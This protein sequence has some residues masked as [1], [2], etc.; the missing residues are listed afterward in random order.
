MPVRILPEF[1]P[2]AFGFAVQINRNTQTEVETNG[3][4]GTVPYQ[5]VIEL[6]NGN[7]F[8]FIQDTSGV[9][10]LSFDKDKFRRKIK[11]PKTAEFIKRFIKENNIQLD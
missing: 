6:T 8:T 1:C 7:N 3:D 11:A 4:V 5:F 9:I 10:S 2:D